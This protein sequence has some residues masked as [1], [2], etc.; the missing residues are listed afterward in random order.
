MNEIN[1]RDHAATVHST[2]LARSHLRMPRRGV[3]GRSQRECT[4]CCNG[5]P[6]T[7]ISK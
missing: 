5:Q 1:P 2:R 7:A 3:A 4:P 6:A